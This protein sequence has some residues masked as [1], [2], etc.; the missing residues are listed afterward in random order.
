MRSIFILFFLAAFTTAWSQAPAGGTMIN[1][2]TGTTYIK[3]GN[4]TL[5]EEAE[6]DVV[7]VAFY[8]R[9]ISSGAETGEEYA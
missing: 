6:D 2:E 7:L 5:T 9:T 4:C 8:A 3:I 1:A